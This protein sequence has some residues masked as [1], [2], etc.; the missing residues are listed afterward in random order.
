MIPLTWQAKALLLV[1]L[2]AVGVGCGMRLSSALYAEKRE[3]ALESQLGKLEAVREFDGLLQSLTNQSA[4]RLENSV[5]PRGT[6]TIE[7][8][9]IKYVKDNRHPAC[10]LDPDWV[11]IYNRS[12]LPEVP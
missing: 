1:A 7:K 2:F 11:R 6:I 12:L 3:S 9:V 4:A 10:M 5:V 8:E